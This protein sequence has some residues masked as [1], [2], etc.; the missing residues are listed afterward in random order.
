[1]PV[2]ATKGALPVEYRPMSP[3]DME[4]TMQFLLSQQ[5]QFSADFAKLEVK[6]DRVTDAVLGLTGSL[7][8]LTGVVDRLTGVVGQLAERQAET[9]RLFAEQR[10]ETDRRFAELAD[11]QKRTDEHLNTVEG[12]LDALI[13]TFERHLRET[14]GHGPS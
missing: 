1:M 11:A 12:H 7:G 13:V 5:A 2:N 9:E 14:H 3:E 8:H 4:R 10:R 6:V